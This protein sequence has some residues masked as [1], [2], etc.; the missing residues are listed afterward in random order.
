MSAS[1]AIQAMIR[2]RLI[3]DPAVMALV[4]PSDIADRHGRPA[5]FP[6]ITFGEAREYALGTVSREA[7]RV[8][9]D[10]HLWT[11]TPGTTDSK[12]LAAAAHRA[13]RNDPW[14]AP[15]FN[16]MSLRSDGTRFMADPDTADVTHGVA[17]YVVHMTEAA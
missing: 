12:T 4:A 13:I 2:A 6:S 5:R 10:L 1:L 15:G 17:S 16:V 3:A 9:I 7:A 14:V 8:V 11:D